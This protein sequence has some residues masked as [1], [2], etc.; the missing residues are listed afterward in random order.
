[1]PQFDL[2]DTLFLQK[3]MF[4]SVTISTRDTWTYSLVISKLDQ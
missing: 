1:M 3:I 2:I 4:V